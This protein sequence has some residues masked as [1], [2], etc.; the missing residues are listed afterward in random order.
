[1][2]RDPVDLMQPRIL[3]V[4][5]ERQVH[6]ALRLRLAADYELVFCFNARDALAKLAKIR[7]D[8]C[9]ADINMPGMD[10]LQFIDAARKIDPY[11]SYV[12]LSAYDTDENLRRLIPLQVCEFLSKPLPE[13]HEF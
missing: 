12:V 1:M 2:T 7:F 4:D 8:L 11:L 10:G 6:A 13:R 9:L 5:D 3:V